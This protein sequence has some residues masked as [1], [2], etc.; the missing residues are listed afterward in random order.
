MKYAFLFILL[1]SFIST[2]G[3]EHNLIKVKIVDN[4]TNEILVGVKSGNKYS[5]LDGIVLIEKDKLI[6]LELI[7][8]EKLNIMIKNDTIIKMNTIK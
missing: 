1:F 7:S 6:S 4:L 2:L 5:D 8:Y 3:L